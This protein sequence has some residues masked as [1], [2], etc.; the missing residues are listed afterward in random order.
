MKLKQDCVRYVLLN[1][2]AQKIELTF[3][4]TSADQICSVFAN[5]KFSEEDIYY[6]LYQLWDGKFIDA[7]VTKV[8]LERWPMTVR[9]LTW[10]GH[11]LLDN[12]RDDVVW[13]KTKEATKS[14]SSVSLNILSSVAANVLTGLVKQA[15]GFNF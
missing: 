6:T 13:K 14:F 3:N 7:T 9:S 12:I 5:D 1:L 8:K 11:E 2:E 10:K 4:G 15:S